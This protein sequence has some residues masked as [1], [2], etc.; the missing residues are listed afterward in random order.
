MHHGDNSCGQCNGIGEDAGEGVGNDRFDAVDIACHSCD[1]IPLAAGGK[2]LL[3]HLFQMPEHAVAHVKGD[4]LGDP[5]VQ[6]ALQNA[7]QICAECH[8]QGEDDQ[9]YQN[10]KILSDQAFINDPACQDRGIQVQ[11]RRGGHTEECQK[12]LLPVGDKVCPDPGQQ[13]PGDLRTGSIL[14]LCQKTTAGT[15]HHSN[16]HIIT[17]FLSYMFAGHAHDYTYGK[18]CISA[19]AFNPFIFCIFFIQFVLIFLIF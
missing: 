8:S 12:E 5:G 9:L 16:G 13:F 4:M 2:K 15:M 19:K 11:N 14:F 7:Y 10:R 3:G 18:I 1:D 6:P 17:S